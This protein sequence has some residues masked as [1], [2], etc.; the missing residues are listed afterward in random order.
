[1][2]CMTSCN[3]WKLRNEFR[4]YYEKMS[5]SS[6]MVD[7]LNALKNRSRLEILN[8]LSTHPASLT[9]IQQTLKS[10]GCCHSQQTIVKEYVEPLVKISLL[11]KASN[12]FYATTLGCRINELLKG[13]HSIEEV[14]LPHSKCYEETVLEELLKSPKTYEELKAFAPAES[15][16]RVL[17]R[18]QKLNL[19]TKDSRNNYIFYFKTKRNPNLARL[20]STE[21][22]IYDNVPEEGAV[23]ET[24]A[25]KTGITLRRTYKYLRRLKGKKLVFKRKRPKTYALTGEGMQVAE[26]LEKIRMLLME[27]TAASKEFIEKPSLIQDSNVL[28]VAK[29]RRVKATLSHNPA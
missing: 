21:K 19:L 8:I 26:L 7:L 13:F 27:F 22:R 1:M 29:K 20:S 25:E 14:L 28:G 2:T 3:V 10:L 17:S 11:E 15:L 4:K 5:N 12:M 6:Y 18:L 16:S 9:Q 23:A 24:L